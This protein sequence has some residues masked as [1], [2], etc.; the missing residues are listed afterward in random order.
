[1]L[2]DILIRTYADSKK[3]FVV[4]IAVGLISSLLSVLTRLQM[5]PFQ[6][7]GLIFALY[8]PMSVIV[9]MLLSSY[10]FHLSLN[11]AAFPES[12]YNFKTFMKRRWRLWIK[13]ATLS[14]LYVYIGLFTFVIPGIFLMFLYVFVT[15]AFFIENDTVNLFVLSKILV[16]K[17]W[18]TLLT[19]GVVFLGLLV[20]V[21]LILSKLM[22]MHPI[23]ISIIQSVLGVFF[24]VAYAKTYRVFRD[25]YFDEI[26]AEILAKPYASKKKMLGLFGVLVLVIL[27]WVGVVVGIWLGVS[28]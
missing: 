20:T 22:G 27:A 16:K 26:P 28:K 12:L 10:I 3:H 23:M 7:P 4:L 25:R 21:S 19:L 2:K 9:Y 6:V 18:G 11:P 24:W 8:V 15:P 14:I 1:M 17:K 13:L 5:A